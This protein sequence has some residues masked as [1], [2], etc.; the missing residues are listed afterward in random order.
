MTKLFKYAATINALLIVLFS[1]PC[2][3]EDKTGN[4]V[5]NLICDFDAVEL[6]SQTGVPRLKNVLNKPN[7]AHFA[8]QIADNIPG[9][10]DNPWGIS[11]SLYYTDQPGENDHALSINR[12]D[13][14]ATYMTIFSAKEGHFKIL[15]TGHCKK[16][17]KA[18]L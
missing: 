7:P 5:V 15:Y 13:G 16:I 9:P 1:Y 18:M 6:G 10:F 3:A 2:L 12:L 11:D 14:S 8:V 4:E 17:D